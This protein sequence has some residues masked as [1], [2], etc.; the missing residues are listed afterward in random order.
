MRTRTKG[1]QVSEDGNRDIDKQYKGQRI[2]TRLGRVSQEEAETWLR[3]KQS[4]I[5]D[6][7]NQGTKRNFAVAADR[8]LTDC[9]KRGVR[10]IDLIAYHITIVLPYIGTKD[11]VAVHSGSLE[12]FID[13]RLESGVKPVTVNRSLEVV[14]SVL[15]K[16]A[17][18]WRDENGMPWLP[19]APLIEMLDTS[20]SSRKP[21]PITW[22]EQKRL[23]AELPPHLEEM[24]LFAVNTGARDDNVCGL[25]WEW[26]R[27]IPELN[28]SV[29]V[30]PPEEYKGK[31]PHVIILNDVA[32]GVVE[33]RR[34]KHKEYVFAY[35]PPAKKDAKHEDIPEPRRIDTI[36]NT[37]WQKARSR[38]QLSQV[39]VHDLRHTYGQRLRAAGVSNEDRAVLLGHA[40]ESMPEHYATPTIARLIEMSN[41][42]TATR[43]TATLLRVVNY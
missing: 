9:E 41:L 29:F 37:A 10:T 16:S 6:E 7:R 39:R 24:A 27:Y 3:R 26:E 43:D 17:R 31:R 8:Y 2:F 18:V 12:S 23:F 36:N 33:S 20:Q 11:L 42:T 34:G 22:D 14:R 35:A 19:S 25:R 32:W 30:V 4:E 5:D 21:Y 28:R 38:A 1:I 13:D 15:V 40:V